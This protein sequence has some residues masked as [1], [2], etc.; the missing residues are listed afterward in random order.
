MKRIFLHVLAM[1]IVFSFVS[2]AAYGAVIS[3]E[4]AVAVQQRADSVARVSSVLL[5]QDVGAALVRM[6]VDPA[7]AVKRVQALTLTELAE[8]ETQLDKLPAGGIGV[9]EVLGVVAVVLIVLE[10]LGV[11]NVFT[12]L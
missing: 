4:A 9:V 7:Q 5:R 12:K 3:T 8:L 2:N 1:S 10:L 11:T 6:G